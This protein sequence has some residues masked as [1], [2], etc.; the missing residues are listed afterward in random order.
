MLVHRMVKKVKDSKVLAKIK[1]KDA[2][3]VVARIGKYEIV[4]GS[5]PDGGW[6][7]ASAPGDKK[8]FKTEKEA[9]EHASLSQDSKTK[10]KYDLVWANGKYEIYEDENGEFELVRKSNKATVGQYAT[11]QGAKLD[12]QESTKDYYTKTKDKYDLVWANGKYEIYEDEN[13]E[14]ELVRKSN[15]ATVGQYATLQGAKLDAQESTKDY[16]TKNRNI[17]FKIKGDKL[18]VGLKKKVKD[19]LKEGSSQASKEVGTNDADDKSFDIR[20]IEKETIENDNFRKVLFTGNNLQLV[21]MSLLPN[22]D[23]GM[24]VHPNVDQFFRIDEGNGQL[25]IKGEGKSAIENGTSIVVKAGTYHNIIAGNKGLKLYTVYAP[26]NYPPD[27][28]QK[29]KA[30]AMAAEAMTAEAKG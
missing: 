23:I 1:M 21:L 28:V 17:R 30:E 19:V 16:Y 8:K 9:R 13:G 7:F 22:E 11:L 29:T 3:Y 24:E 5:G 26:P 15:K 6:W 12:A 4:E 27:R 2:G 20:N 10:D 14:F 25:D 18:P